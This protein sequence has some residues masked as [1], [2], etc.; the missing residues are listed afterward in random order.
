MTT[1]EPSA[2]QAADTDTATAESNDT[3]TTVSSGK[4]PRVGLHS[5][6]TRDTDMAS[7]PGF[8]NPSNKRSKAQGK[9]K[10]KK[11]RNKKKRR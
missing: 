5:M 10:N 8:R 2:P 9:S 1:E 11:A 6:L 7:R 4:T 3:S